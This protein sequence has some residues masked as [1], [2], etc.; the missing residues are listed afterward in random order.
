MIL[1]LATHK[2]SKILDKTENQ[3]NEGLIMTHDPYSSIIILDKH[4]RNK[5]ESVEFKTNYIEDKRRIESY[6]IHKFTTN[7]LLSL[8]ILINNLGYECKKLKTI[9]FDKNINK[10]IQSPEIFSYLDF[11]KDIMT[12]PE[13]LVKYSG[14]N[15]Y[16]Y[17]KF[18]TKVEHID[19][20]YHITKRQYNERIMS[21][22]LV[23]KSNSQTGF[24]SERIY[25]SKTL[26]G[27]NIYYDII[28]G[29]YDFFN[30]ETKEK[31][32]ENE[33]IVY[34]IDVSNENLNFFKYDLKLQLFEDPEALSYAV[35]TYDN[36][37]PKLLTVV[38]D[39]RITK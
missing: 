33:F 11:K 13:E 29:K 7:E 18:D 38:E 28:N 24:H 5:L 27:I 17:A 31:L 12:K 15:L 14:L 10:N 25:L 30:K 3:L 37:S 20:L 26:K 8:F 39:W 16:L 21:Q 4:I 36:I 1:T 19:T 9:K 34:K 32:N 22:G 23:N 6:I 2:L 35:Y